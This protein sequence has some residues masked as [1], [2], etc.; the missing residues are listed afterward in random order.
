MKRLLLLPGLSFALATAVLAV[1]P[2]PASAP[3][4][5]PDFSSFKTADDLWKQLEKL[6]QPPAEKPKSR[7]EAMAQ[8]KAYFTSTQAGAEA[9]AKAFPTDPRSWQVWMIALRSS[10]QLR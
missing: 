8:I 7:E 5:T 1:D 4:A 6:Q 9:F 2:A 3:A 10:M